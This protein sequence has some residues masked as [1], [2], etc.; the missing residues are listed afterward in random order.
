MTIGSPLGI[1]EVQD[2]LKPEYSRRDGFP[3]KLRGDLWVNIF[4]RLDP[5]CGF[6]PCFANDYQQ[7]GTERVKDINEQN[8]G[9]WRHNISNYL[10]GPKRRFCAR[11]SLSTGQRF[12]SGW[13]R[14]GC[15]S[16]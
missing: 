5:V 6:D 16:S 10:G 4:D 9:A 3:E 14:G 1:D 13:R 8:S 12:A 11:A 7:D 2:E 15:R